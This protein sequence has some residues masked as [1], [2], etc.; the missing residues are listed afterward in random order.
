ML[1]GQSNKKNFSS[2]AL[3]FSG[4][5]FMLALFFIL[6]P[7]PTIKYIQKIVTTNEYVPSPIVTKSPFVEGIQTRILTSNV[8][9][10]APTS[11]PPA[12]PVASTT[13]IPQTQLPQQ[14]INLTISEPDGAFSSTIVLSG[15]QTPCSILTEAKNEGKIKALTIKTYGAPLNSDYVQNINGY[16]NNW[17]FSLNGITEPTGCSNYHLQNGN[18]IVWKFN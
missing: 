7:I 9:A 6:F 13:P 15:T 11:T 16:Q 17:T 4:F 5:S 2:S 18:S 12:K 8:S 10:T 14:T 3:L 1:F